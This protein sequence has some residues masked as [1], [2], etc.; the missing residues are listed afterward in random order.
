MAAEDDGGKARYKRI[1]LKLSGEAL[2]GREGYGIDDTVARGGERSARISTDDPERQFGVQFAVNLSQAR[3]TPVVVSAWSRAQDVSGTP[4]SGYSLWIDIEF[5]DGSNLWGQN[6]PFECGSHEWQQRTMPIVP[7][8]PI[9][10]ILIYG[11]FRGKTGTAWFDDFALTQVELAEGATVFNGV[12]V[13]AER[14][15]LQPTEAITLATA[16]GL[17]L[18][19]DAATGA[20]VG[21]DG[22]VGGFFWRDVQAGSDFRQPRAAVGRDGEDVVLRARDEELRLELQARLSPRAHHIEVSGL[23]RDLTGEDRAVSVYFAAPWD[24]VGGAWHDDQRITRTGWASRRPWTGRASSTW[25]TTPAAANSTPPCT[26]GSR[27]RPS[28]SPHRP[29]SR[30]RSTRSIRSG[31]SATRWRATTR[32][33][34]SA[35]PGA[36]GARASGC[37]SPT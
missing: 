36:T 5:M 7:S 30:S 10:T 21:P 16:D 28:A 15:T 13:L 19:L 17:E 18:R 20:I 34:R 1:L 3:P 35:S 6:A 33:I 9:R 12:P 2:A 37:P 22:A 24:A 4:A 29:T 31:A 11:L 8:K 14:V 32:S 26:S 23:V 25:P 27:R